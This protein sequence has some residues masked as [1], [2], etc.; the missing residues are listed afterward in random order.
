MQEPEW[1]EVAMAYRDY[2]LKRTIA[3]YKIFRFVKI[4]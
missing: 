4:T 1:S 3:T 2:L